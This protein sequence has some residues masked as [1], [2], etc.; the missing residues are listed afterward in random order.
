[1]EVNCD[2]KG[3]CREVR[4]CVIT[5]ANA[6]AHGAAAL[7][8]SAELAPIGSCGAETWSACGYTCSQSKVDSVL[9]NDGKCHE[10]QKDDATRP[11]HV[12]ACGRSD[13]CR[14]PFVVH[15]IMKV[16]GAVATRWTRQGELIY[17]CTATLRTC[18]QA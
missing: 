16:R 18:Q 10:T 2:G 4:K 8:A 12:Q 13:P 3:V 17:K 14:V 1:M 15:A 9:M 5:C 6:V 11:C 7:T